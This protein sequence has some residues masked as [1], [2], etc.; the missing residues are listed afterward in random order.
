MNFFYPKK[1]VL[2][3]LFSQSLLQLGSK[4]IH[5]SN[6][7][8]QLTGWNARCL[9]HADL[10]GDGLE[11]LVYFNLD[12]SYLEILYRTQDHIVPKKIR[13]VLKNR[14]EPVLEDAKYVPERI[15]INGSVTD[16]AIGDLNSD[17]VSDIIIGSPV[18]GVR[19]FF[20]ENNSSWSEGVKIESEKIRPYT[21]SLQVIDENGKKITIKNK[22]GAG[23]C[24]FDNSAYCLFEK[25]T[26]SSKGLIQIKS[27]RI[28]IEL[29][30]SS[31]TKNFKDKNGWWES[32]DL[33]EIKKLNNCLYLKFIGRI[34]N[35]F[36]SGGEI[37]FP[38]V[39][40]KRLN[41]FISDKKIPI[42]YFMISKIHL[43]NVLLILT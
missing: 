28:G 32:S 18:D 35:A 15:F 21:K 1:S 30:K 8:D 40:K 24:Q 13:P 2:L 38:E 43:T 16:I 23:A 42:E 22:T 41:D 20:R 27:Q 25:I 14:W 3:L 31:K 10:N 7:E 39:I 11:D 17:S 33:G 29:L 26:V 5:L 19:I 4:P 9:N 37:V 36:N 34:D 6:P 12:K